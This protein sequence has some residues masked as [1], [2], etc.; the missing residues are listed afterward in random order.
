MI[1]HADFTPSKFNVLMSSINNLI[2]TAMD[3]VENSEDYASVLK[4]D[5][6][7]VKYDDKNK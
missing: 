3:F 7:I 5:L 4:P 1:D 2:E 6:E